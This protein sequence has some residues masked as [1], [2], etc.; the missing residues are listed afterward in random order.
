MAASCEPFAQMLAFFRTKLK[1]FFLHC[2]SFFPIPQNEKKKTVGAV[3]GNLL[4]KRK[5]H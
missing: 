4:V 2:S 5:L 3:A 1:M